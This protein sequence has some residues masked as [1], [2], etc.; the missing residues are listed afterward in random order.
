METFF[1][2]RFFVRSMYTFVLTTPHIQFH[3]DELEKS[4]DLVESRVESR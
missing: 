4:A 3:V 2:A 1:M